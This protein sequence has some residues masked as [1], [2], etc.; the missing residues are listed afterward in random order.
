MKLAWIISP[1]AKGSGGFR[2][3]CS[4]ASFMEKFD[5][6]ST[7]FI[8]PGVRTRKSAL[9]VASE[10]ELWFGY[11]VEVVVASRIPSEYDAVIATAWNTAEF[12]AYQDCANKLYFIQDYEPWFY[13]MGE[14]H[15][16]AKRSY[17]YDLK[18]ITIGRWLAGKVSEYY[19]APVPY[20]DFGADL[21]MYCPRGLD[22]MPNS[23][24]AIC[25]QEKDRRI[26]GLLHE[27]VELALEAKPDLQFFL[28]GGDSSGF[29]G[30]PQV[31]MLGLLSVDEC[32]EL[33]A[34]CQLGISLSTS[35]PSRL[36]F[37]MMAAGLPVVEVA[38]E[39]NA[40]DYPRGGIAFAE[41]SAAGIASA[42]VRAFGKHGELA[43]HSERGLAF[44]QDRGSDHENQMFYEAVRYHC[45]ECSDYIWDEPLANE[46]EPA[47]VLP[48]IQELELKRLCRIWEDA[49]VGYIPVTANHVT[50]SAR[51]DGLGERMLK[52]AAWALDGQEDLSWT[53]FIPAASGLYSCEVAITPGLRDGFLSLHFYSYERDGNG[54]VFLGSI[55][56]VVSSDVAD[57]AEVYSREC[58]LDGIGLSLRF[59]YETEDSNGEHSFAALSRR[60]L[61]KG[62]TRIRG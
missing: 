32:A 43:K 6:Q 62:L 15:L 3:I 57:G 48:G 19:D 52:V 8:L 14:N 28:Y 53:E 9:R 33:Y 46:L 22:R 58:R 39:N 40:Y 4:K 44:M 61:N 11:K 21:S 31:H 26:S 49:N 38:G 50:I 45:G 16:R 51:C 12:T 59:T 5:V 27:A 20:C 47:P 36:P 23:V 35:N 1:P 55:D 25:Q 54:S 2:T 18:P 56:Q 17:T 10:I 34:G 37:E 30:K 60:L 29:Y 7:F 41:P 13:P 42:I 24:C